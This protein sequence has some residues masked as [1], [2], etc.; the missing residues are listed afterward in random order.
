MVYATFENS[1]ERNELKKQLK[2]EGWTVYDEYLNKENK[3]VVVLVR[4]I[5]E[6]I[7]FVQ[8]VADRSFKDYE[9]AVSEAKELLKDNE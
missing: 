2:D 8:K 7:N 9:D 4:D 1:T 5:P 3:V 6:L